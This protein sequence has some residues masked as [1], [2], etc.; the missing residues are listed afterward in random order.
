MR[1]VLQVDPTYLVARNNLGAL[2]SDR[3]QSKEA[4]QIFDSATKATETTRV[5]YP[6]SWASA[7]NLA[8]AIIKISRLI[9]AGERPMLPAGAH[10]L[11]ADDD[12]LSRRV[13]NLLRL[14]APDGH[15][16]AV[17]SPTART[18]PAT[19]IWL[20]LCAALLFV[21]TRPY[22]LNVTHDAIERVV[23]LLR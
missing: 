11:G 4:A 6:R 1:K 10:L 21:V 15:S 17:T 16:G 19:A 7:L 3:G 12:G 5:G 13:L 20:G 14:A 2:L 18:L 22:V 8:S 9:P 23:A